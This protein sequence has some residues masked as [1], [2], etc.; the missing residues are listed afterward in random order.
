MN[1]LAAFAVTLMV[2]S[3][4]IG[5][6][7]RPASEKEI[8]EALLGCWMSETPPDA[9]Y[10][11]SLCFSKGGEVTS[12]S[13]SYL[14]GH[15]EVGTFRLTAGKLQLSQ[16]NPF[17]TGGA[18]LRTSCDVLMSPDVA[19]RFENCVQDSAGSGDSLADPGRISF[20]RVA[21]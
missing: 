19:M 21:E 4:A 6:E 16:V 20:F 11:S 17:G 3:S 18:L 2:G 5:A 8:G 7:V 13:W 15:D 12:A 1:L 14:E 10:G 9:G